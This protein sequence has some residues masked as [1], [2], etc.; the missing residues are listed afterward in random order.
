M[1][2]PDS[3][4]LGAPDIASDREMAIRGNHKE[5]ERESDVE[6]LRSVGSGELKQ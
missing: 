4:S 6:P 1:Y 5:G 2:N 3:E